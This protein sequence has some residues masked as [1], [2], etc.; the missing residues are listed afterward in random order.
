MHVV[1]AVGVVAAVVAAAVAA[2]VA[3]VVARRLL[4]YH[5][6]ARALLLVLVAAAP[7]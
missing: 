4:P 7:Y 6:V 2:V 5:G 1:A 3:A